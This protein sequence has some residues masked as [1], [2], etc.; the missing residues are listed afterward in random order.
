MN[1]R[2]IH[3]S[4]LAAALMG[5]APPARR[6][7][8][9]AEGDAAPAGGGTQA[10]TEPATPP[11]NGAPPAGNAP[12]DSSTIRA[13]RAELDKRAKE[14][15]TFQSQLAEL[16]KRNEELVHQQEL[17][18][19]SAEERSK[20]EA[21]RARK[22]FEAQL[23]A[24]VAERD[25]LKQREAAA[26]AE[27]DTYVMTTRTQAAVSK[28]KVLPSAS[29]HAVKLFMLEANLR[30]EAPL[31]EGKP[32]RIVA[33]IDGL[34]VVDDVEAAFGKWLAKAPHLQAHPGGGSGQPAPNAGGGAALNLGA[35]SAEDLLAAGL[36][37]K[38]H[39]K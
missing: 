6:S 10:G 3:T 2:D 36:A 21:D 13:M 32:K 38:K 39:T 8:A 12:Q 27:L 16:A 29:E 35:M 11:P 20:L 5:W 25:L 30:M 28:S 33:T 31:E 1:L 34:D 15:S 23:Q 17:A 26:R 9:F 7:L 4:I 18:G 19:K 37:A 24:T 14:L 22:T